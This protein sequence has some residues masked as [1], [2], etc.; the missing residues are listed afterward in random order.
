[1]EQHQVCAVRQE[2]CDRIPPVVDDGGVVALAFEQ[3]RER[4]T[5]RRLVLDDQH[6]GHE[7]SFA[8][9]DSAVLASGSRMVNVDPL[10]SCDHSRTSPPWFC[11]TC[12]T[13]L[14]PRPV[15]P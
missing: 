5:E 9:T 7:A 6:P 8:L 14:R 2:L 3:E 12:F 4:L 1:I 11:T 15:P 13:M 10:P